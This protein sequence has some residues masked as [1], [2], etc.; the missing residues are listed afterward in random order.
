MTIYTG[1]AG[2]NTITGSSG[3]DFIDGREGNDTLNGGAGSD[4]LVGGPGA[5][6]LT[7]GSGADTFRGS[8]ADLNGDHITDLLIGDRIQFLDLTLQNAN[9]SIVGSELRYNGGSL[10]IDNIGP[11][12]L[13]LR[14]ITSGGVELRLQAAAHNDFNGDG[15]SDILWTKADGTNTSWL[16]TSSGGMVDNHVK[17]TTNL[18][19]NWNV[20]G[21]G[22]FNG[23]GRVDLLWQ[24]T[25]GT[26]TLFLGQADGSMLDNSANFRVNAGAGWTVIGTDDFNGDGRADILWQKTDGTTT[27]WLGKAD[28]T[29]MDN[30]AAFF[31]NAGAGWK[32]VGTGDINGDGLADIVWQKTD[33]TITNWL[34]SESG[35]MIDNSSN[36]WS[37]AGAG[38]SVVGIGDFNGDGRDDLMWQKTDGTTTSWLGQANGNLVDNS[39]NFYANAGAGWHIASI[40]DFNGDAIDDILWQKTDG[41][42]TNWLGNSSGAMTDNSGHLF[43]NAGIG[44]AVHDPFL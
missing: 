13:V 14:T 33:G 30:S 39:A 10:Q 20:V 18:G 44:W 8:A 37:N 4:I 31:V 9:F 5:D 21:T 22:D 12:R 43:A 25:D 38:W 16:G 2:N 32:V 24:N 3:D 1:D 28:G 26:T 15:I 36:F 19:V 11:G 6:I 35:A 42:T 27:N 7:G 29:M 40:G 23:D 34:G 17:F 41:W